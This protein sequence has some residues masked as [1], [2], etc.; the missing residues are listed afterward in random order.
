MVTVK[1]T[2]IFATDRDYATN[3]I[4]RVCALAGPLTMIEDLQASARACGIGK[5]V[6]RHDTAVLF[7]WLLEQL[8]FQGIADSVAQGYMDAHG[9]VTWAELENALSQS[10]SCPKLASYWTLHGC[11]YRKSHGACGEPEHF[12]ACPL[13][14][15]PLRNGS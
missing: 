12:A 4:R 2:R 5:A 15:A 11:G 1:Q 8:S 7:P 14:T 9:T 10:P 6:R 3:L 13:P